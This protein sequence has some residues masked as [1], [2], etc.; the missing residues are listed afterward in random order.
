M[1]NIVKAKDV[2]DELVC[3]IKALQLECHSAPRLV[4]VCVGEDAGTNSYIASMKR[5]LQ[6][7]YGIDID[8]VDLP[9]LTTQDGLEE[10]LDSL[11]NDKTCT[12]IMLMRPLAPHLNLQA[13]QTHIHPL[14]DVDGVHP[15][16]IAGFWLHDDAA[17]GSCT[18]E[19]A[20]YMLEH[21]ADSLRGLNVVVV[22]RSA[23]VGRPVAELLVR[24]DA[25]VTLCHSATRDLSSYTQNAD[26]VVSCAGV[27]H[28]IDASM[29]KDGAFVVDVGMS[30][31][32]GMLLGDVDT[33]D[34]ASKVAAITPV[35]G[36]V[37]TVT[38][39]ILA[40]HIFRAHLLQQ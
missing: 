16:N 40:L 28:L 14:K 32:D 11:S 37:G 4:C 18:A 31:V 39:H 12:A 36:G 10:L 1:S 22:G 24:R 6:G 34:A 20:I 2:M 29:L 9:A 3:D 26:A 7:N 15:S 25:T 35:I 5:V 8:V 33:D 23:E 38:T 19:A 30:L 21:M 13:A 17:F 27:A